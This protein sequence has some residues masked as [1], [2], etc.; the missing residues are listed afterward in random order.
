METDVQ[1]QFYDIYISRAL[2]YHRTEGRTISMIT[3]FR[4]LFENKI[5][6]QVAAD[7]IASLVLSSEKVVL[8]YEKVLGY[9]SF[10]IGA[11]KYLSEDEYLVKLA[12][13]AVALSQS[14]GICIPPCPPHHLPDQLKHCEGVPG[15]LWSESSCFSTSLCEDMYGKISASSVLLAIM[16]I[17]ILRSNSIRQQRPSGS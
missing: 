14:L 11:A 15:E 16:M 7:T 4:D 12:Q 3:T 1:Q 5:E 2:A 9:S 8:S 6:V 10:I 17:I 13:L